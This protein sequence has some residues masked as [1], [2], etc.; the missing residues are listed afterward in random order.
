VLVER[1]PALHLLPSERDIKEE[2]KLGDFK[3]VC[4]A[5]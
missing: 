3:D 5:E 4:M 2:M 1:I